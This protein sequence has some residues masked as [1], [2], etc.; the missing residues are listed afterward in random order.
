MV[1]NDGLTYLLE[2]NIPE[3][4]KKRIVYGLK[5]TYKDCYQ[6]KATHKVKFW[7]KNKQISSQ[8]SNFDTMNEKK[9]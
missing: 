1:L 3:I 9:S 4:E 7:R 8:A 5:S 6:I 2:D